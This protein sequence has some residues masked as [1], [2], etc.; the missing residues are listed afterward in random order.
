MTQYNH[1]DLL[2]VRQQFYSL[3]NWAAQEDA[4]V[5]S[6]H[7]V[8]EELTAHI[9]LLAILC[10]RFDGAGHFSFADSGD[11][12]AVFEVIDGSDGAPIDICAFSLPNPAKFGTALGVV[13]VLGEPN[14]LNP[15]S[16]VFGQFLQ[17]RRHP[18]GW[19]K[20]GCRGVVILDHRSAPMR[21]AQAL[22]P[23]LAEDEA[24]A[25]DLKALLCSAPVDPKRILFPVATIR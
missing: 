19:L 2:F 8:M 9:G 22:G 23:L 7:L 12:C 14:I 18:L 20:G 15:A 10:C 25:R 1:P 11:A 21:L 5:R 4:F 6:H 3:A 17:V 16:W 13:S 24:H